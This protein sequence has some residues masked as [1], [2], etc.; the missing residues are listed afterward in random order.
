MFH[1][2]TMA[3][4]HGVVSFVGILIIYLI[5]QKEYLK[6]NKNFTKHFLTLSI[7]LY[8]GFLFFNTLIVISLMLNVIYFFLIIRSKNIKKNLIN[9]II[10]SLIFSFLYIVYYLIFL[11]IPYLM[12]NSHE[13]IFFLQKNFEIS[14]FG[15]W[16]GNNFG[17]LHQYTVRS[18]TSKL[19]FLSILANVKYLN[20]H[21]FPFVSIIII[22][23]GIIALWRNFKL[24]LILITPYFIITNFYMNGNTAQHFA[25]NFIWLVPF[26]C[27]YLSKISKNNFF[28]YTFNIA[29]C[30]SLLSFTTWAHIYPYK[31]N[32]YPYK[33]VNFVYGSVKWPSNLHRPLQEMSNIIYSQASKKDVIGF[34]TDGAIVLYYLKDFKTIQITDKKIKKFSINNCQKLINKIQILISRGNLKSGCLNFISKRYEFNNSKLKIYFF[35]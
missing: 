24:I 33:I 9:F 6:S 2:Q 34:T 17:Q 16:D 15:N 30:A 4:S 13:F 20:W 29:I 21:F 27:I 12:V 25:S 23:F 7:I 31:E 22:F 10:I 26:S 8:I 28:K 19:N 1:I 5:T 18:N 32:N 35:K 14:D 11:G 3:L